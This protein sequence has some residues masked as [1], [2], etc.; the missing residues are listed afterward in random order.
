MRNL[1]HVW[2]R[3]EYSVDLEFDNGTWKRVDIPWDMYTRI[4]RLV[5]LRDRAY[6]FSRQACRAAEDETLSDAMYEAL[7]S[8]DRRAS[9]LYLK[10]DELV[11]RLDKMTE[12]MD[13]VG[14]EMNFVFDECKE[15]TI[16]GEEIA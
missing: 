12:L 5:K 7:D 15:F 11:D 3:P 16:K 14:E 2:V 10:L 8:V 9:K 4:P 6:D 13:E 1:K